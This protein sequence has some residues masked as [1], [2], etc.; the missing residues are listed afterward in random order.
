MA[1]STDILSGPCS[2]ERLQK[3]YLI[4]CGESLSKLIKGRGIRPASAVRRCEKRLKQLRAELAVCRWGMRVWRGGDMNVHIEF[5]PN[6]ANI[7]CHHQPT[8]ESPAYMTQDIL[9]EIDFGNADVLPLRGG[10]GGWGSGQ[11]NSSSGRA[12]QS[13]QAIAKKAELK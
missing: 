13:H 10:A 4:R 8:L 1:K 9:A 5:S 2:T 11:K 3:K 12:R 6:S 7:S